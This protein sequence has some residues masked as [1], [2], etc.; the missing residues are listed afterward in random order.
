MTETP[1]DPQALLQPLQQHLQQQL[2]GQQDVLHQVMVALVAGGHVLIEGVP[3]LGKTLL[4]RSLAQ[5]IGGSFARIQFT[6]DLM[7]ADI[8]GQMLFDFNKSQ[9][10]LHKGPVFHHLLLADEINRAPAKTQAALLEVMQE[11]QV[12]L[13]GKTLPVPQPFMVLATQNPLEHEGTYAL[14]EAQRDRFLLQ[15]RISYPSLEDECRMVQQQQ[16]IQQR[17]HSTATCL[18]LEQLQALQQQARDL[19]VDD[20]VT[21]YAVRLVRASREHVWLESGAGPRAAVALVQAARAEALLQGRDHV[22]PDDV[23]AVVIAVLQHRLVLSP[24]AFMEGMGSE[25][26]LQQ[27]LDQVAAP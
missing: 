25:Q 11:G 21:E 26:V 16:A 2:M 13:E 3:G 17:L 20:S 9:F 12:T 6:P 24:E 15:L 5:S 27:I 22:L 4:A 19:R 14:P 8:T 10:R 18:T 23:Q 1:I 7:P